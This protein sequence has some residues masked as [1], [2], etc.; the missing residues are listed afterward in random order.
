MKLMYIS[1][2][3]SLGSSSWSE[4]CSYSNKKIYYDCN[5]TWWNPILVFLIL[6]K[7]SEM[8]INWSLTLISKIHRLLESIIF[9]FKFKDNWKS[10]YI[11]KS[12]F[13]VSFAKS[14]DFSVSNIYFFTLQV[15]FEN[16]KYC[17]CQLK[18]IPSN[19]KCWQ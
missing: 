13:R 2:L 19:I 11:I 6:I 16:K 15:S 1:C 17:L 18:H 12:K 8:W 9:C 10:L 4:G 3:R 14:Q 5:T 7:E